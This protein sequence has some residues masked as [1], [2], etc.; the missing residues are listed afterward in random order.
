MFAHDQG[1]QRRL[2][3]AISSG[4][5]AEASVE[6][7]QS[8]NRAKM[9]RQPDPYLR[10]RLHDLDELANRLLHRLVG[11]DMVGG[12]AALP[13]NAILVARSMG[14]AALLDYDRSR[15]R[16]LALEEGGPTSHVAIVARALGIPAIG[17]VEN[18]TSMAEAG[19]AIIVDGG[20]GQVL[21][22]PQPDVEAAFREKARLRARRQEQYRK[23]RDLPRGP[24]D[25]VEVSLHLTAGL[26]IDLPHLHETGAHG[27]GLFRTELQFMIAER[28]PSMSEQLNLYKLVMETA[29]ELPVTF[30]TLDIGGDKVLPYMRQVDEENPALGWR[31]IRIGLDRPGLLRAQIRAMLKAAAGRVIKIMLPMIATVEEF[32]RAKELV[33]RESAHLDRHG[34]TPPLGI[35]LGVMVEVPS[36]LF[37]LDELAAEADFLSVGSNDLMQ[38]LFAADRENP[39]MANRFDPLHPAG[40]RALQLV[41][42]AGEKAGIPVTLCGE[43]G[44]KPLEAMALLAIGYRS[45][46]MSPASIGPLKA[47]LLSLDVSRLRD[48]VEPLLATKDGC[49]TIRPHLASFAEKHGVPV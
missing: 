37:Q 13:D 14:P 33:G 45:L 5:T 3:E 39:Q 24:R 11:R 22:R 36:L 19:D 35:K 20:A 28:L 49:P 15:L 8:D 46:S 7:V 6:R 48:I 42:K 12:Q 1:W 40:L 30:R 4:L 27:I 44:G 38:F 29:G 23:L 2:R 26:L 17:G 16:G 21:L 32:R 47:M 43:L 34:Y 10:E 41:A 18:L 31:A 25:G 9:M